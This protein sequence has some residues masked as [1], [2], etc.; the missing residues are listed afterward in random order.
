LLFAFSKTEIPP[1]NITP[2]QA[3]A[4]P[5]T[6]T[7]LEASYGVICGLIFKLEEEKSALLPHLPQVFAE[8]TVFGSG[9]VFVGG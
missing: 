3:D 6:V 9:L 4:A 2:S 5:I 7:V 8:T 1:K